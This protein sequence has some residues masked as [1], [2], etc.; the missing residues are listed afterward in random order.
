MS[1]CRPSFQGPTYQWVRFIQNWPMI[2]AY[3]HTYA[4]CHLST[5]G[6][7]YGRSRR[8]DADNGVTFV[9]ALTHI[10]HSHRAL[11][12]GV[13]LARGI[14][15]GVASQ[16]AQSSFEKHI[17]IQVHEEMRLCPFFMP[18]CLSHI[19]F[20]E[21]ATDPSQSSA[22]TAARTMEGGGGEDKRNGCPIQRRIRK[23]VC[24]VLFLL[25]KGRSHCHARCD[26]GATGYGGAPSEKKGR[27]TAVDR[28]C[29]QQQKR[30]CSRRVHG[31]WMDQ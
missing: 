6:T 7:Y 9:A 20:L 8:R 26:A 23:R 10:S 3:I 5:D 1:K 15:A 12:N 25:A 22:M 14:D 31:T 30:A 19:R 24:L 17:H 29:A 11:P 21:S 28:L 16:H 13:S 4:K 2:H 27:T 18:N